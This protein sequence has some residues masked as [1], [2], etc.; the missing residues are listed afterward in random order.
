[1]GRPER[2]V[3]PDAGPVQR[4]AHELRELRRSAGGPSY[5]TMAER[6]G[7]A[8]TTLS[9]A[10]AGE[11]L[12]SWGVV[13]GYVRACDGDPADWEP[14]WK[15]A[16]A[17]TAGAIR[18]DETD[19]A[20]PYR[21]LARFEPDDRHLFFG[22]DR[23]VEE[24][25]RLVCDQRLA[26]LFGASGSGKSSLLRAGL[27]PRLREAI[28]E[29]GHPA[30]LRV[31][32]PGARPAATYGHLL[33]P[34]EGEPESWVV[35]DQFEEVFTLCRDAGERARF[36]GML[37]AARDPKSRLKV[38]ISVRADFYPRCAEH[39]D[40]ADAL[41]G[42]GLLLGP[43]TA[44]EL[45]AA[46]VKPAQAVGLLV[47]RELTVRIVEEVD[48]RAGGLP[49]LSHALL[50]TWRRRKS[51]LL[52]LAAY[53]AAGG[54]RG[55]IAATAE[56]VFGRL[57][58]DQARTAR[59]LL[60]RMVEP[61]HGTTP[62]TR[63]PMTRA[64]LREY[65]NPDVPLVL[66]RLTRA[67]LL[68]AD[69]DGVELAHEA[70][71]TCWPRLSGWIDEDRER[72][73]QHRRLTEVARAWQ[74]HGRDPGALYRGTALTR[75]EELFPERD[76]LT[77]TERAFLTAALEARDAEQRAAAKTA[78]RSRAVLTALA[79]VLATALAVGL[80]AWTQHRDNE[81]QR[82]EIAARRTASVA[83]ALRTT[84]P[85]T[86]MLL[87]V[88]AWRVSALPESRRALLGSVAQPERDTF[89][90]PAPGTG[91]GRFLADSGRTL[92]S[93][94]AG[95][96]TTWDV[97]THKRTGSGRLPQGD[98][99]AADPDGRVVAV[100]QGGGIRLWD[101]GTGRWTGGSDPVP[102]TARVWIGSDSALTSDTDDERLR[103]RSV[104]DGSVLFEKR[105]PGHT[106]A[107]LSAD[108]GLVAICAADGEAE[109][110]D[111]G[112]HRKVP[113]AWEDAPSLC[114]W[115]PVQDPSGPADDLAPMTYAD[116]K[117]SVSASG[118]RLLA[119]SS[120][121]V[122]VWNTRTGR[123]VADL[124]GSGLRYAALSADR[125][126]LAAADDK[127]VRVW[128]LSAP[129]APVFRHDLNNQQPYGLAWD[130][131]GPILRYLEGGTVHSLDL[132]AAVTSAWQD[133]PFDEVLLSPDGHTLATARLS[134][135]RYVVQLR[136][137]RDGRV[138]RT[139]PAPAL[140]V[141]RGPGVPVAPEDTVP[142]MAFDAHG[143]A[144]AY[145]VFAPGGQASPQRLTVW[146]VRHGRARAELDLAT[147]ATDPVVTLAL[148]PSGRTVYAGRV[149]SSG[150]LETEVWDTA[151]ARR[152]R[153][154]TALPGLAL[155]VRPDGRLL[156]GDSRWAGLPSGPVTDRNL[157]LGDEVAALAFSAD[158]LRLAA[159]DA[160]GRV[161]LWDGRL[162]Q[163]A[164]V[165]RNAFPAHPGENAE[166]IGAVALSPDGRTL[167]VGGD[168]GTL[169][170]WDTESQQ[171]LGTP[172]T[173]AGD[174][175]ESLSFS[176][177]GTTVYVA[178]A[179]VPLQRYVIEPG[180]AVAGVCARAGGVGL[181]RAQ[182][183]TYVGDVPYQKVCGR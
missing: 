53:E 1:M 123:Q 37:L 170:L 70:L 66:D 107:A 8:P 135:A 76:L 138:L 17:A 6:A 72:L 133:R 145:G 22:R 167:A 16:E 97:A 180:R 4:L 5:R 143:T 33:R 20:P 113:G 104:D 83:D 153:V 55:A 159:G 174:A 87:G 126:F 90:D 137:T 130:P 175:V 94:G 3:D 179:H 32:T 156:V 111:T 144:F 74:E 117:L 27:I 9:Q 52:T 127:E 14:R 98:V 69:E 134:G 148:G 65:S 86:A 171:P 67:R 177:D 11:R 142:L 77:S 162:R 13:E 30:V 26:V 136:S 108:G 56:E 81:R 168:A 84:D 115:V 166:Q 38:L 60:L 2:P 41:C 68:T 89:T 116:T 161:A 10:A 64:E 164:G 183:R 178:G 80:A 49:M 150:G 106:D 149:S 122:R 73:R 119:V 160:K 88:A 154:L 29:H 23:T 46:V 141:S 45:R 48:G 157:V 121:G 18:E 163:R 61:G 105:S 50:E 120:A 82:T 95:R 151:R 35:V 118:D 78:R 176:P 24:L 43:M 112:G 28:A 93:I 173:T 182:W 169:Q 19:A 21:G 96:W 85:R 58:P 124:T 100:S 131:S 7:F 99:S 12:P 114:D 165:L 71:I 125:A 155:A 128:R 158:G 40:L 139:L 91:P 31:F 57:T 59:H 152:S 92:L 39:R 181:T 42:A 63:R 110:W 54:V 34:A 103:V 79:A 109:V 44:D 15:E 101:T 25:R 62:D 129:D 51:R 172:L 47:E 75:A 140:P 146:D 36:I 147:A 102:P 132:G